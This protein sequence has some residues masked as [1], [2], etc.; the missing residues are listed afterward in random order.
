MACSTWIIAAVILLVIE[1][2]T[3]GVFFFA[4]LSIGALGAAASCYVQPPYWIPWLVFVFVSMLSIYFLR[5]IARRFFVVS[6][7]KSN[8]DSLIG[9][10]AWV[11]EPIHPPQPGTIKIQGDVWRAFSDVEIS[12]NSYVEIVA[13][14][15][16]HLEVK[17]SSTN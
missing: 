9:Q 8:V 15:G 11:I 2:L 17:K 7:R 3:P 4:C 10:K 13:V 14:K 16:T 12:E 5:P 6:P 1:I